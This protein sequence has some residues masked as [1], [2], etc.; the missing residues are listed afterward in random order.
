MYRYLASA[1]AVIFVS[2]AM[3]QTVHQTEADEMDQSGDVIVV[4]AARTQLPASALPLTVDVIDSE[5]L[6]RQAQ[7][8]GSTVD[9]VSAL[10]PSFSPTR[11]KLSGA[12]ESLRGRSPLYA[13]NGIPQSTPVRDGSRD[14]YTI[15][16]FFIDRVE[17]IYGSNALQGVGATGGVVNQVTVGAPSEDGIAVR[18]LAQ[19]TLPDGF[20]GE[21][22]G[23]KSGGLLGYRDGPLDAS[24]GATLERRG[25]FTICSW[26]KQGKPSPG[27]LESCLLA[28]ASPGFFSG[29]APGRP[30][31]SVYGLP[32]SRDQPLFAITA[33]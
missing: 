30:I 13:I 25:A 11:E 32:A 19:L 3:A 2:P 4:T 5:S 27:S 12:G 29:G 7:I 20:D 28:S 8:S 17:V 26:E 16:P 31:A 22:I 14:G 21:G 15:D 18:A 24:F 10:L 1:F 6:Q 23:A 33:T 9:A